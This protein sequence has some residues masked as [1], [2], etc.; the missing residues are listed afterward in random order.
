M[1][2]IEAFVLK[3]HLDLIVDWLSASGRTGPEFRRYSIVQAVAWH[4]EFRLMKL[5]L[6]IWV[7]VWVW[8]AHQLDAVRLIRTHKQRN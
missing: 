7:W 8:E 2:P 3:R 6:D 4:P 1:E 5:I